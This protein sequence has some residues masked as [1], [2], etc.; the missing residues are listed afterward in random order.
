MENWHSDKRF[1]GAVYINTSL[2]GMGENRE[3]TEALRLLKPNF[4]RL[5]EKLL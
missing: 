4:L 5:P 2:K 1:M 3:L